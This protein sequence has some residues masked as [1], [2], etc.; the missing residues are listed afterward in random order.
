[1]TGN[2]DGLVCHMFE[3]GIHQADHA[4]NAAAGVAINKRIDTIPKDIAERH[5]IRFREVNRDVTV[6]MAG[7]KA[8]EHDGLAIKLECLVRFES[9]GRP[10]AYRPGLKSVVP[11]LYSRSRGKALQCVFLGDDCSAK[12]V[13]PFIAVGMIPMPVGIDQ[14]LERGLTNAIERRLNP[15]PRHSDT[16]IDQQL[17]FRTCE[18]GDVPARTH[19]HADVAAQAL[20]ADLRVG[21]RFVNL[22]DG[23]FALS[24]NSGRS[25]PCDRDGNDASRDHETK[26]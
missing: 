4:V 26:P 10:A 24:K 3:R 23:T 7:T 15:G 5:H 21:S 14:I 1:M 11:L 19:Q 6:S 9:D 25:E 17:P 22:G 12:T 8:L 20:N 16:S 18:H 13:H 2:Y